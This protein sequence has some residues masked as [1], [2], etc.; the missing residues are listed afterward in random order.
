MFCL[1]DGKNN[2]LIKLDRLKTIKLFFFFIF[3]SLF[4]KE[5]RN[6]W[7]YEDQA[8]IQSFDS[9]MICLATGPFYF[10]QNTPVCVRVCVGHK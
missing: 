8:C 7:V 2:T 4:L 9:H 6:S 3:L 10:P 1:S 5:A